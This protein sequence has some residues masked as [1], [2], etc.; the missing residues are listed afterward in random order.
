MS[1]PISHRKET[2]D[3]FIAEIIRMIETPEPIG[4]VAETL[5]AKVLASD[6]EPIES[7]YVI[8]AITTHSA[9][10][11]EVMKAIF[12]MNEEE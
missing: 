4:D 8:V 2:A 1:H 11:A 7:A 10:C 5:Y 3:A 6:A 9:E 12:E